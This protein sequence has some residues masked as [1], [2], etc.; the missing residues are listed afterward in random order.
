MK[1]LFV[2]LFLF[3]AFNSNAQESFFRG[4]N[5]YVAPPPPPF[6]APAIVSSG[7]ILNLDAANPDSYP[8]TGSTWTNLITGNAVANFGLNSA[9]TY[10]SSNGG[11]LRFASGGWAVSST[12]FANL[13]A[14]TVE[15]WVKPAGTT[16]DYDQSLPRN[17]SITNYAPCLFSEKVSGGTVNMAL[18]YNARAW[19]GVANNSYHYTAAMGGWSTFEP[20]TNYG[21]DLTNWVQIIATY[22]GSVLSLYRNGILLGSATTNITLRNTSLGYFIAHRWDMSDGVYGDYSM[23]NMYNRALTSSEVTTNFNA[24]KSRFGL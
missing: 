23:V 20:T 12:G 9:I 11:I 10:N 24:V 18:A 14:Y 3:A 1:K 6:Q 22:N 13:T 17:F 5:N 15:V 7:L 19:S 4:N 21:S 8:R 16:G 2:L